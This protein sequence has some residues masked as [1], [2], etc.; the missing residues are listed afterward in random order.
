MKQKQRE[1]QPT[2]TEQVEDEDAARI[3]PDHEQINKQTNKHKRIK[4]DDE[5]R[6]FLMLNDGRGGTLISTF[7]YPLLFWIF[8]SLSPRKFRCRHAEKNS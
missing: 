4:G 3:Y 5:T 1:Q 8:L 7:C 2:A 6:C